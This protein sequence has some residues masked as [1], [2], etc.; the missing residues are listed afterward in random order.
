MEIEGE[1][2]TKEQLEDK[3]GALPKDTRVTVSVEPSVTHAKVS[4]ILEILEELG[5]DHAPHLRTLGE[6]CSDEQD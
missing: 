1:P 3:L 4:F 5:F 2:V 6:P